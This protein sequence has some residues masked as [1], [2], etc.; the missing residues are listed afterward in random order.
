MIK[1]EA[2]GRGLEKEHVLSPYLV[3]QVHYTHVH[4]LHPEDA[5]FQQELAAQVIQVGC[6]HGVH[7]L[8][9]KQQSYVGQLSSSCPLGVPRSVSLRPNLLSGCGS[10][11]VSLSHRGGGPGPASAG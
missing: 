8:V 10:I 1:V 9:G 5:V 7:S 4:V 2:A 6:S 11:A 3:G